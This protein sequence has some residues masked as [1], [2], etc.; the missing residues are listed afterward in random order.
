M[1]ILN[2][3]ESQDKAWKNKGRGEARA[4]V[5]AAALNLVKPMRAREED[6]GDEWQRANRKHGERVRGRIN[7]RPNGGDSRCQI[8]NFDNASPFSDTPFTRL[9]RRAVNRHGGDIETGLCFLLVFVL[10]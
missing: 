6:H 4:R 3:A 1:E 10:Q 2:R 7:P 8:Q 9:C 5:I